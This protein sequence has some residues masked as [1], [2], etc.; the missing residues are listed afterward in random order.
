MAGVVVAVSLESTALIA[1]TVP[2]PDEVFLLSLA[3]G[4]SS[5][6]AHLAAC[7]CDRVEKLIDHMEGRIDSYEINGLH[8]IV[9]PNGPTTRHRRTAAPTPLRRVR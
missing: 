8:T 9:G 6:V 7:V 5:V 2:I 3:V 1:G 4:V